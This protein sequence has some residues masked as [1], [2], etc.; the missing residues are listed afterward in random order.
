MDI[1]E[2]EMLRGFELELL[3]D[4]INYFM[5][6][7]MGAKWVGEPHQLAY[8]LYPEGMKLYELICYMG[9][10]DLEYDAHIKEIFIANL[11]PSDLS[12]QQIRTYLTFIYRGEKFCDGHIDEHMKNLI[13]LKLCLRLD[14][15]V[16]QTMWKEKPRCYSYQYIRYLEKDVI[17]DD[18]KG[19]WILKQPLDECGNLWF[20][21]VYTDKGDFKT[22]KLESLK[23]QLVFEFERE[24]IIRKLE[25]F[26]HMRGAQYKLLGQLLKQQVAHSGDGIIRKLI[27]DNCRKGTRQHY[28]MKNGMVFKIDQKSMEA[29]RYHPETQIWQMD[30]SLFVDFEHGNIHEYK[31]IIFDE[32][33]S[34][35]KKGPRILIGRHPS[36]DIVLNEP[37]ASKQ[38]A[39]LFYNN[40]N[41][42]IKDLESTNGLSV[43]NQKVA[44]SQLRIGDII[45]IGMQVIHFNGTY[46]DVVDGMISKEIYLDKA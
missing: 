29:Y 39:E 3:T 32:I 30:F 22:F 34:V 44:L 37:F 36:C 8:P 7:K 15:L 18:E 2:K 33:Y 13:L 25:P 45:K 31:K 41:W 5:T 26:S 43:N 23:D 27:Q 28:Q 17:H 12:F 24:S 21:V 38:H 42:W 35:Q 46:I 16:R 1:E 4:N 19:L 11:L 20:Y 6:Y 9:G 14:D 40:G 10:F